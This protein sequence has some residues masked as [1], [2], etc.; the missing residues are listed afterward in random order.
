[1]CEAMPV[2]RL[3]GSD[4]TLLLSL[5]R[6]SSMLIENAEDAAP[7]WCFRFLGFTDDDALNLFKQ[8]VVVPLSGSPLSCKATRNRWWKGSS[9]F[10]LFS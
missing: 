3:Y 5:L 8:S 9:I 2:R 1:M 10:S 4:A 6:A 7:G